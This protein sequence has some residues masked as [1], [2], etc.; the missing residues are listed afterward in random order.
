MAVATLAVEIAEK[1]EI[2]VD[3]ELVKEGALNHDIGRARTQGIDHAVRG[4]EMARRLGMEERVVNIIQR[5]IGAGISR[6]EAARLGL[7]PEDF[8]PVT[9]EEIVVAYADNLVQG[10][11]VVSYEEALSRFRRQLGEDHPAVGRFIAMHETVV[12]WME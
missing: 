4:A 6:Q 1:L 2:C 12:S 5:H 11:S 7:P 9:P 10:E 8:I 3:V